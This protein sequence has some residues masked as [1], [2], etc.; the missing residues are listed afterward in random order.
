MHTNRK[1]C[2][3]Y[4]PILTRLHYICC[5]IKSYQ[6]CL[7]IASSLF[8]SLMFHVKHCFLYYSFICF[9]WNIV[10]F[11]IHLYVSRETLFSLFFIYM[12]HVEHCFLYYSFICFTWNIVFFIIH[13][14]VSRETL[15]FL[16]FI[17]MFH[18]K[19]CFLYYLF[20][21]FT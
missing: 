15:F 10:F 8:L 21:C 9:T 2:G 13:L 3:C 14:Y 6:I 20:I 18:V 17:Y 19:H 16:F 1:C 12:F 11:I 7:L 5:T 4:L